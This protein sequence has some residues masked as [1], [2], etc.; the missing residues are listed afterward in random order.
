MSTRLSDRPAKTM[1][2]TVRR[3]WEKAVSKKKNRLPLALKAF[4]ITLSTSTVENRAKERIINIA[5]FIKI[6]LANLRI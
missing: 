6:G 3:L 4:D 2:F 5:D 1:T